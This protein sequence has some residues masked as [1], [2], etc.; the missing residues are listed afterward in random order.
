MDWAT[1]HACTLAS[2]PARQVV[3]LDLNGY[4]GSVSGYPGWTGWCDADWFG[5]HH[6]EPK[7]HIKNIAFVDGH[8]KLIA[9]DFHPNHYT[10]SQYWFPIDDY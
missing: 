6:G 7:E 4:S 10:S 3:V 8:V 9:M 5:H 1:D 2:T